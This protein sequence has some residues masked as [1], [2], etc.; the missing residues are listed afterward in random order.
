MDNADANLSWEEVLIRQ[1]AK[2]LRE[3]SEKAM[4][5]STL[6]TVVRTS[7]EDTVRIAAE[8]VKEALQNGLVG[9]ESSPS[10]R[11]LG[12]G[13]TA[14]QVSIAT[15]RVTFVFKADVNPKLVREAQTI[16]DLRADRRLREF[17]FRLPRIYAVHDSAPPYAYL[18]EHFDADVYPS[19][20]QIFFK[21]PSS[22]PSPDDASSI[23]A[24]ALEALSAAYRNSKDPRQQVRMMGEAYYERIEK[25]LTEAAEANPVFDSK[26]L[27]ING[28]I[29]R[30]WRELLSI[31]A[32]RES[33]LQSIAA[34]F[35]TVVH[36]DPNPGNI[37]VRRDDGKVTDVKFIDVKDWKTGDYLFDI[38]KLGHFLLETGP[39]EDLR[40]AQL[41]SVVDSSNK[42][43]FVYEVDRPE[44]VLASYRTLEIKTSALADNLGDIHWRLRYDLAMASNLLGLVPR[45][46]GTLE[47]AQLLY[48][49]GMLHFEKFTSRFVGC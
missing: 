3:A 26:T 21:T 18:M 19:V 2:G 32:S 41:R 5:D 6:S 15:S 35:V 38:A 31:L 43:S 13:N 9:A 49:A 30:P 10:F 37:L 40:G 25:S 4:D 45:R 20:R 8:L 24:G 27:D 14:L 34:P 33:E 22:A 16:A 42:V 47:V 48:T 46:I 28:T 39:I 29:T 44:Y 36:G 1:L 12:G 23:V 11:T 17:R 7:G